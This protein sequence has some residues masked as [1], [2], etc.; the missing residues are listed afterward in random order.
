MERKAQSA[1]EFMIV[2]AA[3]LFFYLTFLYALEVNT[4]NQEQTNRE[5]AIKEVA[6]SVQNEIAIANSASDGYSR[7]F[8]LPLNLLS[9]VQYQAAIADDLIYV[10]TSHDGIALP[11][12]NV[13]GQLVLGN[14]TIRKTNGLVYLN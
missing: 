9:G 4:S 5:L 13:T 7:T 3:F 10:N 11:I 2:A 12:R 1:I 6:L 8:N 14:N